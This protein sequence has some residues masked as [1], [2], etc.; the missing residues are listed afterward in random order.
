MS[1]FFEKSQVNSANETLIQI[2]RE[3]LRKCWNV[4]ESYQKLLYFTGFLLLASAFFHMIVL[5]V[6][7]DSLKGDI[8]FRK[9]DLVW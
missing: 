2:I 7:V 3:Q 8:S 1:P 9:G 5:I 4:A 6:T